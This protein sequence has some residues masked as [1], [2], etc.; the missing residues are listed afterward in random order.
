MLHANSLKKT[1]VKR[2]VNSFINK[3]DR[4][5]VQIRRK[6]SVARMQRGKRKEK[7]V[8]KKVRRMV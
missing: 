7:Q 3:L 5:R 2:M 6:S 4:I 1:R 8:I